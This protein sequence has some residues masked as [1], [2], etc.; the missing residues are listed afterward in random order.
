MG[1]DITGQKFG[2]LTAIR[3]TSK[4]DNQGLVIWEFQCDCGNIIERTGRNVWRGDTLSCGCLKRDLLVQRNT[5][6]NAQKY[7]IGTTFG[8]LTI[9]SEIFFKTQTRGHRQ[10]WVKCKCKCGNVLEV[11]TNNLS[12]GNT[13][14][15]GCVQSFGER[16]IIK[17]LQQ[18]D[19]NFSTQYTFPDLRGPKGGLLRFDFAIFY[20]NK[21]YELIEFDGRQHFEG[22]DGKWKESYSLEDIQLR[23][24]LKNEYCEKNNIKLIRISYKDLSNL[25]LDLL[26]LTQITPNYYKGLE[27]KK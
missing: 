3:P 27:L 11:A 15:C 9:I 10:S 12:T 4:R 6:N 14:S 13:K 20:N 22:P 5:E 17:L 18:H 8:D 16:E 1:K 23:D 21:L 26:N 7:A 25:N 24:N 19:I 2:R